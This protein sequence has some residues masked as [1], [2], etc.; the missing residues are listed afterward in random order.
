MS[1]AVEPRIQ[2]RS[3]TESE[4]RA[5]LL[6]R[7]PGAKTPSEASLELRRR[8]PSEI[9]DWW[10]NARA[11]NSG[12]IDVIDMFSG[13]GGMS[14]GFRL[15]NAMVP[16]FRQI[17][18]ID[19]DTAANRTFEANLGLVPSNVD[20]HKLAH[21]PELLDNLLRSSGRRPGAPLVLIGCSPCQGFSSH[22][23]K[24]GETDTRNLL[25]VD[26]ARIA[27]R[28]QPDFVIMEN[29]PELLTERY[30]PVFEAARE[31]LRA[32]GYHL[33]LS[34]HNMAEFGVPQERFRALVLA[35]R[36]PFEPLGGV[37]SREHF[38]T[39][40]QAIGKLKPIEAGEVDPAD[41]MHLT[42]TH[43]ES[44]IATIRSIPHNG[45]SRSLSQGPESLRLLHA[46]QGKAAYEDVY[47]RLAWDRP[48]ITITAYSRN[49]ASGRFSHPEQDRGLSVR[50]AALLQGFPRSYQF[51][52]SFD[53]RF[54][55]IGNAVPP[56]FGAHLGLSVIA[57][58]AEK[59]GSFPSEGIREPVAK[60]FSR[61]IPS[62]KAGSLRLANVT[63]GS[64]LPA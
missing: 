56:M 50:E 30:W 33:H 59:P 51:D 24:A 4:L 23:N 55:Q 22:R 57:Q 40:R 63:H 8:I 62:L 10:L 45:G 28:L 48:S 7:V 54:R 52:G 26:F 15:V 37:L 36:E 44:T 35:S 6:E 29:V 42:A 32:A 25:F 27:A 43:R 18:A 53:E 58:L 64:G 14:A 9:D 5:R 60:S 34:V 47:G 2:P 38:R 21:E 16:A 46:R 17:A 1:V 49:P 12:P 61:L 3:V 20:V 31:I 11:A 19:V 13:C 39:V 41:P